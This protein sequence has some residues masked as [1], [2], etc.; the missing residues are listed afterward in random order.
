MDFDKETKLISPTGQNGNGHNKN[1]YSLEETLKNRL[2]TSNKVAANAEEAAANQ[3][4][5]GLIR[6]LLSELGEDPDREGLKLTP[7]RV[8]KSM[9]FLTD[10]YTKDPKEV[11]GDAVFEEHYDEM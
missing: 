9:A 8:R 4:V 3:R 5:E 10:G 6:D 11:M 1:G 7:S 2:V